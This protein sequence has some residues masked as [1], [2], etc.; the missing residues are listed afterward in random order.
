[1]EDNSATQAEKICVVWSRRRERDIT[2][3]VRYGVREQD[4]C[5]VYTLNTVQEIE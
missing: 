3:R 4:G 1:M 5:T 2:I